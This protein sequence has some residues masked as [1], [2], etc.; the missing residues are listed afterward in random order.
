MYRMVQLRTVEC[1]GSILN[2]MVMK[3]CIQWFTGLEAQW[4]SGIQKGTT[5]QVHWGNIAA[6][7]RAN[8]KLFQSSGNIRPVE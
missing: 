1:S 4:I 3:S 2:G 7:R 5:M 6:Y 8:K